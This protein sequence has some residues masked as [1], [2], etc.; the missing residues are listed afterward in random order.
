MMEL[1]FSIIH[2]DLNLFI[3]GVGHLFLFFFQLPYAF[4]DVTFK[5]CV[6]LSFVL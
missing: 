2:L 5:P 1:M 3:D 6:V 4:Q